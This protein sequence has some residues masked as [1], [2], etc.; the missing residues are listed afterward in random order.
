MNFIQEMSTLELET[1]RKNPVQRHCVSMKDKRFE[2]LLR[3]FS[4]WIEMELV[5]FIN[6]EFGNVEQI[7][8]QRDFLQRHCTDARY[9]TPMR[10]EGIADSMRDA[11]VEGMYSWCRA[12]LCYYSSKH[13][14]RL[15]EEHAESRF[16]SRSEELAEEAN[17][18]FQNSAKIRQDTLTLPVPDVDPP[19]EYDEKEF[20]DGEHGMFAELSGKLDKAE[21]IW[22]SGTTKRWFPILDET[23]YMWYLERRGRYSTAL[24]ISDRCLENLNKKSHPTVHPFPERAHKYLEGAP[25]TQETAEHLWLRYMGNVY[26]EHAQFMQRMGRYETSRTHLDKCLNLYHIAIRTAR[27]KLPLSWK[28]PLYTE[29]LYLMRSY[30]PGEEKLDVF[31]K[32]IDQTIAKLFA[33]NPS[34]AHWMDDA[35]DLPIRVALV[36]HTIAAYGEMINRVASSKVAP[37]T[38]EEM[39][40][41]MEQRAKGGDYQRKDYLEATNSAAEDIFR[42]RILQ[43]RAKELE[44][45]DAYL[46]WTHL[47]FSFRIHVHSPERVQQL[48]DM[49]EPCYLHIYTQAALANR[50]RGTTLLNE[51]IRRLCQILIPGNATHKVTLMKELR[52]VREKMA[53]LIDSRELDRCINT[54]EAH[55][56]NPNIIPYVYLTSHIHREAVRNA[57]LQSNPSL[58]VNLAA[59][60]YKA[61]KERLEKIRQNGGNAMSALQAQNLQQKGAE[62]ASL[63]ETPSLTARDVFNE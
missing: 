45:S 55:M 59:E 7:E 33:C 60:D 53:H 37:P 27:E 9:K 62:D 40:A 57:K 8:T 58:R 5:E 25:L 4:K 42:K 61:V 1:L 54:L 15:F 56:K 28:A 41:M 6:T 39:I 12:L 19:Y 51:A 21:G 29:A 44:G 30:S 63:D 24:D 34:P 10:L 16:R 11:V 17:E 49:Y 20:L 31:L 2:P 22:H 47:Y 36:Y 52:N 3:P 23:E 43:W 38:P 46:F 26:F 18:H 35:T 48:W 50:M 14:Y 32:E 13:F